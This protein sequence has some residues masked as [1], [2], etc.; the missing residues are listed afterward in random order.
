MENKD[1]NWKS[2]FLTAIYY[3]KD[4]IVIKRL[5]QIKCTKWLFELR[6]HLFML[7]QVQIK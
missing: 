7:G 3:L 1:S 6:E 5:M 4:Y 2:I